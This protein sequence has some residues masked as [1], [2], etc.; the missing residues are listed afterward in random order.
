MQRSH[1]GGQSG[2]ISR[3]WPT[4]WCNVHNSRLGFAWAVSP[5]S[6]PPPPA[7]AAQTVS[8]AGIPR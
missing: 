8:L 1:G 4:V 7:P 5:L 2:A 6:S 3:L